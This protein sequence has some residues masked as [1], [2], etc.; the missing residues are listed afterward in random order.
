MPKRRPAKR[1]MAVKDLLVLLNSPH[2][3]A[4]A[5][6]ALQKTREALETALDQVGSTLGSGRA[7]ELKRIL[8]IALNLS[9]AKG[10]YEGLCEGRRL[11]EFEMNI[12]GNPSLWYLTNRIRKFPEG[13]GQGRDRQLCGYMD[14]QIMRLT[15]L[16]T[17]GKNDMPLPLEGWGAGTWTGALA[18]SPSAVSKYISQ[19]RKKVLSEDYTFLLAWEKIGKSVPVGPRKKVNHR[20]L[21]LDKLYN[22]DKS[23]PAP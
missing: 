19:A 23:K 5:E 15:T 22:G 21:H 14:S 9:R 20:D 1:R 16:R 17:V 13:T 4:S 3:N 8:R 12:R 11:H 7:D 10:V 6:R 2:R 18:K